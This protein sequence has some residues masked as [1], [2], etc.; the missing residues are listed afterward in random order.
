M[1][2]IR[3]HNEVGKD[4]AERYIIYTYLVVGDLLALKQDSSEL[5]APKEAPPSECTPSQS[6]EE[7]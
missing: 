3:A 7:H 2:E 4:E 5:T 1:L 6:L